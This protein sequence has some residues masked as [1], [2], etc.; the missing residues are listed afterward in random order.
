[1]SVHQILFSLKGS[2]GGQK[3][4]F[5]T[6][7]GPLSSFF[8][9]YYSWLP[10][11]D[12]NCNLV[13]TYQERLCPTIGGFLLFGKDRLGQFPDAWIQ[14]GRFDGADKSLIQDHIE[15]TG[16]LTQAI[17]K[18]NSRFDRAF[19]PGHPHAYDWPYR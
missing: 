1:M 4:S 5:K 16:M 8:Y 7:L 15:L 14:A 17:D 6:I 3:E 19:G 12:P 10:W 9:C 18:K 2:F 13:T 11:P